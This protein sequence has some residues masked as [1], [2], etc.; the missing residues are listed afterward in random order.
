[1][2]QVSTSPKKSRQV[3]T[4]S[5]WC[6]LVATSRTRDLQRTLGGSWDLQ[7]TLGG[8]WDLP[9]TVPDHRKRR[10]NHSNHGY[11][12]KC[13]HMSRFELRIRPFEA[14][15]H[16]QSIANPP[17]PQIPPENSKNQH[18]PKNQ[19]IRKSGVGG[20]GRS[21]LIQAKRQIISLVG[22]FFEPHANVFY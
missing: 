1:M 15:S 13:T 12:R 10:Q 8:S 2:R 14:H 17:R 4:S 3:A 16:F 19:K 21:P 18:F 5:D 11:R 6:R 9:E 7:G 22:V 20:N